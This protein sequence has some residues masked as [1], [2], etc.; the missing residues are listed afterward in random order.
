M[1]YRLQDDFDKVHGCVVVVIK[2]DI[3]H[4]WTFYLYL[5]LFE[6]TESRLIEGFKSAGEPYPSASG[7]TKC[8]SREGG[9]VVEQITNTTALGCCDDR[10]S[11][12]LDRV[13][14]ALRR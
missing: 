4:A 9:L 2:D 12:L 1:K 11:Q 6:E 8:C 5:I 7:N 3:P 14:T 13:P 10:L